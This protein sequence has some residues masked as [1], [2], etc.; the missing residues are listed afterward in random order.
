M[1]QIIE[2]KKYIYIAERIINLHFYVNFMQQLG[3]DVYEYETLLVY[4][5]NQYE[6]PDGKK[7]FGKALDSQVAI[8]ALKMIN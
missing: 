3:M 1:S 4:Q 7:P 6:T 5:V 8:C 2:K